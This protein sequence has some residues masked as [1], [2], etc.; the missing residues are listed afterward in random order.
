MKNK[1]KQKGFSFIELLVVVILLAL[2][3]TSFALIFNRKAKL[4][5]DRDT[6]AAA[7]AAAENA[8]ENL[9]NLSRSELPVGGSFTVAG[10]NEII[11]NESCNPSTC[12]WLVI[13]DGNVESPAKGR[14]YQDEIP[15]GQTVL[16]RRW[17]V[18]DIPG[19]LGLRRITVAVLTNQ[20][21]TKPISIIQTVKGENY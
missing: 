19:D 17:L 13:P 20:N 2:V 7:S 9:R 1:H 3:A 11:L 6:A 4:Y 21:S 14:T 16:L 10:D 15:E 5:D 18:E 8:I 12:D